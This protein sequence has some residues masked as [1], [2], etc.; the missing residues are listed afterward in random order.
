M[1]RAIRLSLLLFFSI[2]A[3]ILTTLPGTTRLI[4]GLAELWGYSESTAAALHCGL[5]ALLTL[6]WFRLAILWLPR[7]RAILVAAGVA[8]AVGT[9]TEALQLIIPGRGATLLDLGA[10]WLGILAVVGWLS[11]RKRAHPYTT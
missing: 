3:I 4:H 10:N 11:T 2:A 6:V 1:T 9:T 7:P 8:L 5:F